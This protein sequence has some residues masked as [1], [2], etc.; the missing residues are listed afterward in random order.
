MRIAL[1]H[2]TYWPEVRRGAERLVHDLAAWLANAGHDVTVLTTHR[3][4][5]ATTH[6][7]GFRV[8][9]GWRPPDRLARRRAYEDSLGAVPAQAFEVARGEFDVAHGFFP[10]SA[11]AALQARALG[12]PPVVYS[13]LGIATREYL[14][15]R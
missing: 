10:V 4:G 9:R 1:L 5:P 2:P 6:A 3:S 11:W 14:V 13:K 8:V 12:G 15:A 7:D